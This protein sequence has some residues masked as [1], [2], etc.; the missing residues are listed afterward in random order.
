MTFQPFYLPECLAIY[1]FS[2][3]YI[4]EVEHYCVESSC[5]KQSGFRAQVDSG[6]SFTLLPYETYKKVVNKVICSYTPNV[7]V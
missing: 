4:V 7:L 6:S 3:K 2:N 1:F 5:L